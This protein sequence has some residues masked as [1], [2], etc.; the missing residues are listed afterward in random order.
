MALGPEAAGLETELLAEWNHNACATLRRNRPRWNV[1]EGD[2]RKKDFSSYRGVDLVAGGSP[3]Q[4]FSVGGLARSYDDRRDMFP[5]AIRAVREIRPAAFIFENVR[6]LG[7]PAF[8]NYLEGPG[9]HFPI[10]T[11]TKRGGI[12]VRPWKTVA[13][14]LSGLPDPQEENN[15]QGHV[16]QPGA[17]SYP[18]HTGSP[19]DEPSKALKAGNHGVPGGENM[20]RYPDGEVR[21]YTTR[22][23]ARI[24]SFPDDWIVEGAWSEA[25]RQIGNAVPV[26]FA[27]AV[28]SSVLKYLHGSAVQPAR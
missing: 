5:E 28:A 15:I 7:R 11:H 13:E 4:P 27:M 23:A 6:G 20:L 1:V 18:G 17:K 24:Q 19:I 8:R 2:V 16:F 22:E 3:C 26:D 21:D 25:V 12:N 9:W 14:A 10:P